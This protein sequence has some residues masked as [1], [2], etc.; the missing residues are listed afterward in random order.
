MKIL[1]QRVLGAR[2]EVL[3][4][5]VGEIQGIGIVALVGFGNK[6]TEKNINPLLHKLVHLRIF[7][8]EKGR[9][10]RSLLSIKGG[11]LLVPQFTL[12]ADTK[13][14]RRPDFFSAMHPDKASAMFDICVHEA[15]K[16][17][18]KD[19]ARIIHQTSTASVDCLILL[20]LCTFFRPRCA[21]AHCRAK[22]ATK[23]K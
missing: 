20:A 5:V 4:S 8:D 19:L 10:D 12:F 17:I 13:K 23:H 2:V 22:K 7:S 15:K 1:I 11:L 3:G 16:I 6:D 14:G 18:G 21:S 9:F